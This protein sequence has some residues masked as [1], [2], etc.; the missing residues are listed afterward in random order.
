MNIERMM[1]MS[2]F[3]S[4]LNPKY[5][6]AIKRFRLIDDTF[7]NICFNDS[8]ECMQL[9]LSI[10]FDRT[11][12]IVREVV[13]QRSA[14]N[15]YGRGVR[16]DVL[17]VDGD[18]KIYNVEIQ[19]D[20]D[21]ANPKRARFNTCLIDSRE[22]AKSTKYQDFPEVWVIFITE[23][24]L[25]DARLPMYHV[26]RVITELGR[27]FEDATHI[28]YVNGAYRAEDPIGL[29]MHDFFCEDPTQ[30]H[31]KVLA[32]R[33]D[34]FKHETRGVN[35]MCEIMQE[36]MKSEREEW[37][38][39]ERTSTAMEMLRDNEPMDKIIKY[40]RLSQQRIDELSKQLN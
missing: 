36:L 7:F 37:L 22:V 33:A 29:L 32:K 39:E 13:T 27:P 12:I 31:Y 10:I 26:E 20:S 4:G 3:H 40:S 18:G 5:L 2:M 1:P 17:A 24:D 11:D 23:N 15:L 6:E 35:A 38:N 30:M 19:R 9:L 28:A 34:F 14:H 16:F 8:P 21:G 25:F